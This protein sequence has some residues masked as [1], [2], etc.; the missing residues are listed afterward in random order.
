MAGLAIRKSWAGLWVAAALLG[1]VAAGGSA[2]TI[3]WRAGSAV[4]PSAEPAVATPWWPVA[5]GEGGGVHVVVQLD[6][7]A[8]A[9]RRAELAAGGLRLLSPLGGGNYFA[10]AAAGLTPAECMTLPGL[11]GVGPIRPEWKLH[12][13]LLA[14]EPPSWARWTDRGSG[15]EWAAV[16]VVFHADVELIRQG[17]PLAESVGATVRDRLRSV[18]GLVLELPAAGIPPLA[19]NDLVQWVEPAPPAWGPTNDG[20]RFQTGADVVQAPPYGLSGAGVTVLVFDGGT[21]RATHVDFQG[22]L[23][24]GDNSGM[25]YHATHVAG[26][27]GGGG[28]ANPV[29]RGM[30]PGV[31]LLSYGFQV[32]G[33]GGLYTNPG[34]LE[35]DYRLA[36][37]DGAVIANNSIGA[38]VEVN[39]LD[40][41]WQ[42]DYSVTDAL[43]DAIVRGSLGVPFRVVWAGGNERAGSRCDVEGFGDYYSI[44]PP[45]GAKNQITVGAVHSNSGAMTSFSSWGP[46]D[47]GRLKPDLCA[48]GCQTGGDGGITSCNSTSDTAY[49]SLCGT[50]QAAP[51]VCGLSALLIEDYRS[52]YPG[53]PLLRN[54]TIKALLLH[55]AEDLGNPGPDY[56]YGYGLAKV[57]PAVDLLRAG[58]FCEG[59]VNQG[60]VYSRV[61]SVAPGTPAFRV[62]LAW[63]DVPGTP[64]VSPALVND[65]DLR[66]FGP[67]GGRHYPWTLDPLAPA[68][69]AIR[70]AEDH[71]NNVEQVQVENP[72]AGEWTIEVY[73][74]SV[75]QGPQAFSLAG[76][77]ATFVATTF[78]FPNGLPDLV[79]PGLEFELETRIVSYGES[80][81]PGTARLHHRLDGG[82]WATI[83]LTETGPGEYR[84]TLP[85]AACGQV[86]EYYFSVETTEQGVVTEPAAAPAELHTHGIGTWVLWFGD[87]FEEDRGW[88]VIP[89]AD[90][91][92]WERGDPQQVLSSGVVVQPEDDHTPDPGHL[93]YV[94][95]AAA[96]GH[97][98][99]N[100]VD[101]GPSHLVSPPLDLSG[102]DAVVSYWRWFHISVQMDDALVVAVTNDGE[103]WVTVEEVSRSEQSWIAAEWRVSDYVV[104]TAQVR[105]RFTIHDTDPGSVLESLVDDFAVRVQTCESA[106]TGDLNCD[107]A[108]NEEDIPP[109]VLAL[110][111]PGAYAAEFPD[112]DA[113]R[114]DG[115]ADGA[116]DGRDIAAFVEAL[117]PP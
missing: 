109:F 65:L 63:D 80:V 37:G 47:D 23:R 95:G 50:S 89:G 115:N 41:A 102:T 8:D 42:G 70:T 68:L 67:D 33:G 27:I 53:L 60:G 5:S 75:P 19:G 74:F 69:P 45:S 7:P 78:S 82:S 24:V 116:I 2:Q 106:L 17:V 59:S 11:A 31:A 81:V 44:S 3:P 22:R 51:V 18:N 56:M 90:S 100:D 85:P 54:S 4:R 99:A 55:A 16:C 26:T 97:A 10:T 86:P 96:G 103:N 114:A 117:L 34:D 92:N 48:P 12:P 29:Y 101:G 32:V 9:T 40:C 104:P 58:G 15:K 84:A 72:A 64:N 108:V 30:A 38:N 111:D 88:T 1:C 93:C 76:D 113:D 77:G 66:V 6:G 49:R 28:V 62:T 112:C 43:V 21:A 39:G 36:I 110:I 94:T 105:V 20:A 57:Q 14:G 13:Q 87:D 25:N 107:Q 61:V 35:G 73:G 79:P 83:P 46:T 52:Q 71:L 91:G 98:A